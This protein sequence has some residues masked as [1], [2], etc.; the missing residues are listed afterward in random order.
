MYV[1]KCVYRYVF[2]SSLMLFFSLCVCVRVRAGPLFCVVVCVINMTAIHLYGW[3]AIVYVT[4]QSTCY[5]IRYTHDKECFFKEHGRKLLEILFLRKV[6]WRQKNELMHP[7][8][9]AIRERNIKHSHI[10]FLSCMHS[11]CVKKKLHFY[12]YPIRM[13]QLYGEF[14]ISCFIL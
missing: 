10:S 1:E 7:E 6:M 11:D 3:L 12:A 5:A 14:K 9:R 13:G 2:S 8:H 4:R